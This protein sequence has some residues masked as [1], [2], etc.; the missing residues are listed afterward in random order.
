MANR[1]QLRRGTA[2]EWTAANPV[3]AQGEPGVETDTGKQKFGNGVAAWS[4]LPYASQ[5]PAG[6]A[7]VADDG[8][9]KDLITTP[10]S[11]TATALSAT[12]VRFEDEA[13]NPL[14]TRNVVIKVSSTT[15]EILDIVS[16]A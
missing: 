4:A 5:G 14:P 11:Q 8:S 2:A 10:G 6:T 12:Y 16:E 7:G 1:I 3:L 15:G 13:G 9:V